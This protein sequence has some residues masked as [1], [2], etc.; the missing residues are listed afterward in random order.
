MVGLVRGARVVYHLCKRKSSI[1]E[2]GCQATWV[3]VAFLLLAELRAV[4]P[5]R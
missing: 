1:N 4:L 5:G 3:K 2:Q